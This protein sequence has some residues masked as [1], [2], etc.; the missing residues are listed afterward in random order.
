M[1]L[2]EASRAIEG[3]VRVS[4]W[5]AVFTRWEGSLMKCLADMLAVVR[6]IV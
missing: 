6:L 2:L 1:I 3:L 5:R 4:E